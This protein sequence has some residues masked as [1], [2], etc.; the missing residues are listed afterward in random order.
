[1][2]LFGGVSCAVFCLVLSARALKLRFY[3]YG[4]IRSSGIVVCESE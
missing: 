2:E 4:R 1:M 3:L